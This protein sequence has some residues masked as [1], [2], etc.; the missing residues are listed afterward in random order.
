MKRLALL[1]KLD[2]FLMRFAFLVPS[3]LEITCKRN[4]YAEHPAS[5]TQKNG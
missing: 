3:L 1:Y 5:Y 4:L 2:S